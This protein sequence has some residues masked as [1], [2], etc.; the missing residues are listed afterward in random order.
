MNSKVSVIVPVY[1]GG[2][3]IADTIEALIRQ[4]YS[5][6]EIIVVNDGSTDNTAEVLDEIEKNNSIVRVINQENKG[7]SEARNMGIAAATGGFIMFMD[8]DD[9]VY[10]DWIKSSVD[11][12]VS[13]GAEIATCGYDVKNRETGELD[14]KSRFSSCILEKEEFIDRV[15]RHRDVLPAVWNKIFYTDIIR[16]NKIRFDKKYAIG[17]DLLFLI[18]Y[19][20]HISKASVFSDRLYCYYINSGGAMQAHN[21]EKSFKEKWLTEWSS[22]IKAEKILS[23]KEIIS[24]AV[25]VKKARIADKLISI[26]ERYNY[27]TSLKNEMLTFLRKNMFK[28]VTKKEFPLKKKA[29]IVL[30][31]ISPKLKKIIN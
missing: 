24:P 2:L 4:S 7:V 9:E 22:I 11:A 3:Y 15:F 31:C 18:E 5:D 20:L 25:L 30:N 13:S 23:E 17:E 26:I 10:R 19:S 27:T 16:D 29:S 1:N 12:I 21:S 14:S 8:S 6:I 28:A